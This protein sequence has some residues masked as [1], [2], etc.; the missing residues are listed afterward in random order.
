MPIS[1]LGQVLRDTAER[2]GNPVVGN[3]KRLFIVPLKPYTDGFAQN[4]EL[5]SRDQYMKVASVIESIEGRRWNGWELDGTSNEGLKTFGYMSYNQVLR[6]LIEGRLS[7]FIWSI[8]T[9]TG[10][11]SFVGSFDIARGAITVDQLLF[12]NTAHFKGF[13]SIS[14]QDPQFYDDISAIMN[15]FMGFSLPYAPRIH[16]RVGGSEIHYNFIF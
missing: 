12:R 16:P 2:Y 11:E 9:E 10:E 8:D 1:R 5:T 3:P 14:S 4:M 6:A 13:T 15:Y 7:L